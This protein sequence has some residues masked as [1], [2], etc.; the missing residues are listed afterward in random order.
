MLRAQRLIGDKTSFAFNWAD[1]FGITFDIFHGEIDNSSNNQIDLVSFYIYEFQTSSNIFDKS[2]IF[3]FFCNDPFT[4]NKTEKSIRF[5]RKIIRCFPDHKNIAILRVHILY[6]VCTF[7][8]IKNHK[9]IEKTTIKLPQ[10]TKHKLGHQGQM[11]KNNRTLIT[12]PKRG[13]QGQMLNY[14]GTLTIKPKRGHQQQMINNCTTPTIA[15]K[16]GHQQQILKDGRSQIVASKHGHQKQ[17]LINDG[18]PTTKHKRGHQGKIFRNEGTLTTTQKSKVHDHMLNNDETRTT[19]P[20]Q[21]LPAQMLKK[22]RTPVVKINLLTICLLLFL[23]VFW[24]FKNVIKRS[25]LK[26]IFIYQSEE[27]LNV[28]HLVR[29][30]YKNKV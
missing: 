13:H 5:P 6:A 23:V 8:K 24:A 15:Y 7:Y 25:K 19:T 27:I 9:P 14:G 11:L 17:M 4:L 10:T 28:A 1:K 26:K 12:T 21:G 3:T 29:H 2:G 22:E 30:R 16:P 20:E 18:T